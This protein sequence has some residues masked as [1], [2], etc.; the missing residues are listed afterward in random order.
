MLVINNVIYRWSH[1]DRLC[2][3]KQYSSP[4]CIDESTRLEVEEE[5]CAYQAV[6]P[7][8][9]SKD[10]NLHCDLSWRLKSRSSCSAKCGQ[11]TQRLAFECVRVLGS[12]NAVHTLA[13][14]YC[15]HDDRLKKPDDVV[16]CEGPCEGVKW[17]YQPWSDC[18]KSC[19]GGGLQTR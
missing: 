10:C 11:G 8:V 2:K 9:K 18:S 1:C 19:G 4:V 15:D 13:D 17:V 3:G 12:D 5:A 6:K 16:D 14:Q 7:E